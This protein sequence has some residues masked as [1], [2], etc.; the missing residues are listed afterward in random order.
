MGAAGPSQADEQ[1]LASQET[2]SPSPS[3][4]TTPT[5][6]PSASPTPSPSPTRAARDV[7]L[8]SSRNKVRTGRSILLSG[9]VVSSD[10]DCEG[11]ERV[12]LR[13][14]R[15]GTPTYSEFVTVLTSSDGRF[16]TR[17]RMDKTTDFRATLPR[18]TECDSAGSDV[19]TVLVKVAVT[20][21]SSD[22]PIA[23]GAFFTISGS[24]RPGH[25][26]TNVTLHR[27]R[28][29]GWVKVDHDRL[30]SDSRYQFL[31]AA[32]WEGER[33]FRVTW[34]AQ[35]LDHEANRS[36]TVTLRTV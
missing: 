32:G 14:R 24:V 6:T 27:R 20:I 21:H 16:S 4:S 29:S 31:L 17:V 34:P 10:P 19:V 30:D 23:Q 18:N 1:D 15:F 33:T 22:N 12:H 8:V 25:R 11:Q 35:D 3:G 9:T 2:P 26:G 13:K 5:S 28:L 7:A 36:N